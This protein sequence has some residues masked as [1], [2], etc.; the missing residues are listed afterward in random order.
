MLLKLACNNPSPD[1]MPSYLPYEEPLRRGQG[2][3]AI[4]DLLAVRG[5][6]GHLAKLPAQE[7]GREEKG[8][9]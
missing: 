6:A 1:S 2:S 9:S 4:T 7:M 3:K 8:G 5:R